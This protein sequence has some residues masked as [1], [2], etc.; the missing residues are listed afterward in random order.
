M[1]LTPFLTQIFIGLYKGS[2]YWILAL[3]LVLIFGVVRVINFAHATF[4]VTG[5]YMMYTF[6][7]YT[8]NFILSLTMATLIAGALGVAFE[9]AVIRRVYK[10]ETIYQL[11]ATFAIAL[12]FNEAQKLVWGKGVVYIPIPEALR[13]GVSIGGVTLNYYMILIMVIGLLLFIIVIL[14]M[15]NTIMGLRIRAVWRDPVMS[16][17][18]G[19]STRLIYTLV[20]FVGA[21]LAGLGGALTVP[22]I[23]VGPGLA[24]YLIVTAFIVVVIAGLGSITGAYIISVLVGVL[25]SILV[26]ITP[27]LDIV[28]LYMIAAFILLLRP[29]GLFGER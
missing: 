19:V 23:S 11:L 15:N 7:M 16:E 21:A 24:D 18:L 4:Y 20:F 1:D 22:L 17:A 3:G 14:F 28:I 27:E 2:L 9:V 10:L 26:L 8:G 13:E 5:S 29:Q 6:Y 12:I 25:S